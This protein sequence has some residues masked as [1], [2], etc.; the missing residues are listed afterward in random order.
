MAHPDP[1][2]PGSVP[3]RDIGQ[4]EWVV[5]G[6]QVKALAPLRVDQRPVPI[7]VTVTLDDCRGGELSITVPPEQAAQWP[8]GTVIRG[9]LTADPAD[10]DGGPARGAVPPGGAT[11]RWPLTSTHY[12]APNPED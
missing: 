11:I 9:Q 12:A 7:A 3:A 2:V 1:R 5:T 8:I 6:Q 10:P 4:M